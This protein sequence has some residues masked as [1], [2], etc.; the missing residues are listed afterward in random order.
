VTCGSLA[1]ITS[2]I[3]LKQDV[4]SQ[5]LK[6]AINGDLVTSDSKQFHT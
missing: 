6:T 1:D 3:C 4:F 5:C 2:R